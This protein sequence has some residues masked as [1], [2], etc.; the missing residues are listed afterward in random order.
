MF[1][2]FSHIPLGNE[3]LN[4]MANAY[5]Q[6]YIHLIFSINDRH[7]LIPT[8]HKDELYK[9]I[10]G[11]IKNKRHKLIQI[12]GMPN[13]IHILIGLN[14]NESISDVIKEIK[15]C[16][17][18][19]INDRQWI[20]GKFKWQE[21]YGAFSYSKSQLDAVSKY[22]ENQEKHHSKK[23]FREEYIELMKKFSVEFD[24]KYI[25]KDIK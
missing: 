14:P 23:T 3:Y 7:S 11:I 22:I 19:F 24:S 10:T 16:S 25:F 2:L 13:H 6:I 18:N 4:I 5:T 20:K 8:K 1:S 12:N 15:R 17:T 9:Y 21:G